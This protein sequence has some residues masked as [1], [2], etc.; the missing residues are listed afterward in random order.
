[1][2]HK[3]WS[4]T[5]IRFSLAVS[6]IFAVIKCRSADDSSKLLMI[7]TRHHSSK[8]FL[9]FSLHYLRHGKRWT[10]TKPGVGHSTAWILF[11]VCWIFLV[12]YR[13]VSSFPDLHHPFGNLPPGFRQQPHCRE[14]TALYF[15]GQW[16]SCGFSAGIASDFSYFCI[17][18]DFERWD[19]G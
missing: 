14:A 11:I 16:L 6:E 19:A 17:I 8:K 9:L 7:L 2:A 4:V 5:L 13:M 15:R 10:K 18:W 1:M 3:I 12:W